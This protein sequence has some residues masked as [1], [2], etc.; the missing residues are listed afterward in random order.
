MAGNRQRIT[1]L[2][3]FV[4]CCRCQQGVKIGE[5]GK[6]D[7]LPLLGVGRKTGEQ[8]RHRLSFISKGADVAFRLGQYQACFKV[9][10]AC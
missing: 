1:W 5:R 3:R 9:A 8:T 2:E 4:M 10:N 6:W 7:S